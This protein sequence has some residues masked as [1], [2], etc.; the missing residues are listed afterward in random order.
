LEAPIDIKRIE[1]EIV[2]N[3][4]LTVSNYES[5]EILFNEQ[6][7]TYSNIELETVVVDE[8]IALQS[9]KLVIESNIFH[10]ELEN[11]DSK[12]KESSQTILKNLENELHNSVLP[13]F[14]NIQLEVIE[15]CEIIDKI[16]PSELKNLTK[17]FEDN[18]GSISKESFITDENSADHV[19]E[20]I[21]ENKILNEDG[22]KLIDFSKKD[23][24]QLEESNTDTEKNQ[25]DLTEN[26]E[27]V[28]FSGNTVI[29]EYSQEVEKV[30]ESN[31]SN[32]VIS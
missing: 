8:K 3:I 20:I 30:K 25:I 1:F 23:L 16:I 22:E 26:D 31:D 12:S 15:K 6:P 11:N 32:C 28:E 19:S 10:E 17:E 2:E 27:T 18:I 29:K 13:H 7:T 4:N 24:I 21:E 5:K 14:D 9:A